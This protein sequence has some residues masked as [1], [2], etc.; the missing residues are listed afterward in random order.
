MQKECHAQGTEEDAS[1][2][3]E[4]CF[5]G[6]SLQLPNV[7]FI[8][9]FENSEK[10]V[11]VCTSDQSVLKTNRQHRSES[12]SNEKMYSNNNNKI[13]KKIGKK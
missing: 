3:A 2:V 7:T 8:Y 12:C 10:G 5:H 4:K 13:I 6:I 9:T 1:G 11:L